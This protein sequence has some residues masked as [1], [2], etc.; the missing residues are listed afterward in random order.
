MIKGDYEW[1]KDLA[2][3]N[4]CAAHKTQ[5]EVAWDEKLSCHY[6]RCG[7]CGPTD[8][9]TRFMSYTEEYKAGLPVPEIIE[10]NI[11]KGERK[12][13]MDQAKPVIPFELAGVPTSDLGTGEILLPEVVHGL[14]DYAHK[15]HLDPTRGHVVLMY[16]KPYITIDGYLFHAN[17]A[18]IPY[19]LK[20]RPLT[21]EERKTFKLDEDDHAWW[22]DVTKLPSGSLFSGIGIVTQ[23]EMTQES[24]RKPGQLASPVVAAHPWLLAQKRAEWQAMRRAF[25]IGETL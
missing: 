12:K 18:N 5:L 14:V 15:Y 3:R 10:H 2:S 23:D 25:P 21:E 8:A 6:L 7:T 13:L 22:T 11:Q 20:S 24:K 19:Q 16:G 4:V 17:Q 1:L 9:I